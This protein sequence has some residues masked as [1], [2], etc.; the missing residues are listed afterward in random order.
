MSLLRLSWFSFL[1]LS[2]FRQV[3]L[4][5]LRHIAAGGLP[6]SFTLPHQRISCTSKPIAGSPVIQGSDTD[7]VRAEL[8]AATVKFSRARIQGRMNVSWCRITIFT[9][10]PDFH[11][12][13]RANTRNCDVSVKIL[14]LPCLITLGPPTSWRYYSTM[15]QPGR[16]SN[17]A[18]GCTLI[19]WNWLWNWDRRRWVL[20][21]FK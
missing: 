3:R 17:M 10:F 18:I 21:F 2:C 1:H 12:P 16:L 13:F 15:I 19:G 6:A 20:G 4:W 14:R 9:W 5:R 8:G 11:N 7:G